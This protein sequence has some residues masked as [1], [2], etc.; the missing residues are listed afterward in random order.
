MVQSI[1]IS[2]L[3]TLYPSYSCFDS[4]IFS[5][6]IFPRLPAGMLRPLKTPRSTASAD[7]LSLIVCRVLVCCLTKEEAEQAHGGEVFPW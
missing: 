3:S 1:F 5:L 2:T 6:S 4:Y 7:S